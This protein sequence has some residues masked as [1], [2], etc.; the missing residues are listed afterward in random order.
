MSFQTKFF[1]VVVG[2][3][4]LLLGA[5]FGIYRAFR[6]QQEFFVAH[7]KLVRRSTGEPVS[8]ALIYSSN[9]SVMVLSKRPEEA[10]SVVLGGGDAQPLQAAGISGENGEFHVFAP[11]AP[12]SSILAVHPE[13]AAALGRAVPVNE[14]AAVDEIPVESPCSLRGQVF[15]PNGL[16]LEGA[17][18]TL[19]PFGAEEK[20]R[21][22]TW[23]D[24]EGKFFFERLPAGRLTV[25]VLFPRGAD[26]INSEYNVSSVVRVAAGDLSVIQFGPSGVLEGRVRDL[27]NK[28]I[29]NAQLKLLSFG[30]S[31]EGRM[32]AYLETREG[33]K[34]QIYGLPAL[35]YRVLLKNPDPQDRPQWLDLGSYSVPYRGSSSR[36]FQIAAHQVKIRIAR[37]SVQNV[38]SSKE[39]PLRNLFLFP[40]NISQ[41]SYHLTHKMESHT[42]A[43]TGFFDPELSIFT[44]NAVPAGEYTIVSQEQDFGSAMFEDLVVPSEESSFLEL[45]L[46]KGGPMVVEVRDRNGRILSEAV[47]SIWQE[48][49]FEIVRGKP[50]EELWPGPG[51]FQLRVEADGFKPHTEE[52]SLLVSSSKKIA[53][54]L[55]PE[56]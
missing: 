43:K 29:P 37:Q 14:E 3:V 56:G 48:E 35:E 19:V 10:Q 52:V 49:K 15:G 46:A 13:L 5:A 6:Q 7:G 20:G 24:R 8:G 26:S 9:S 27:E 11:R 55:T 30:L 54:V 47:V 34:F 4:L 23:S 1:A 38:P 42:G 2:G 36:D 21:W 39:A 16:A 22:Q 40:K 12:A 25:S 32:A 18:V 17:F 44:L 33:G 31:S 51:T 50:G 28:I 41:P 45:Y 53:V